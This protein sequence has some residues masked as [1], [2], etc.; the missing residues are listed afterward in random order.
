MIPCNSFPYIYGLMDKSLL[1]VIL[2]TCNKTEIP[3]KPRKKAVS[4]MLTEI[5]L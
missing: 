2:R 3:P 4:K 5:F 1:E